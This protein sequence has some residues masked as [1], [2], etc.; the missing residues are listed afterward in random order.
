VPVPILTND[1]GKGS[2]RTGFVGKGTGARLSREDMA[3]FML[4]QAT[5]DTYLRQAPMIS[6]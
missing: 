6:N 4:E 2:I 3:E 5:L 1:P